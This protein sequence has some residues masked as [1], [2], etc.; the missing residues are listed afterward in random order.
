MQERDKQMTQLSCKVDGRKNFIQL[1]DGFPYYAETSNKRIHYLELNSI[2]KELFV[3]REFYAD[4]KK[5][6]VTLPSYIKSL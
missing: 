1:K 2:N 3:P 5:A 6:G 4:I